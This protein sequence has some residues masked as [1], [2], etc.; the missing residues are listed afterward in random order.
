MFLR[1]L[2]HFFEIKAT[3]LRSVLHFLMWNIFNESGVTLFIFIFDDMSIF[4]KK[5]WFRKLPKV[6]EVENVYKNTTFDYWKKAFKWFCLNAVFGLFPLI[7]MG[8]VSWLTKGEEG[9][10]QI[11]HLIYEGGI[12]LFVAIA[13]MGAVAVDYLISGGEFTGAS[14]FGLFIFPGIIAGFISL[15]FLLVCLH[16]LN[17]YALAITSKKTLILLTFTFLYCTLAKANLFI[18]EDSE[19]E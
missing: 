8:T 18:K 10:H 19:K 9:D 2:K 15:E 16:K 6:E 17:K 3:P 11:D 5:Y 7:I 14:I 4:T 13:I 12:V 1:L